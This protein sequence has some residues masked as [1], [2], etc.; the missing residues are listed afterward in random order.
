[1]KDKGVNVTRIFKEK[2]LKKTK[3]RRLFLTPENLII[4]SDTL[5][6]LMFEVRFLKGLNVQ[7][8][9]QFEFYYKDELYKISFNNPS[10]SAYKW[11]KILKLLQNINS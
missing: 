10:I 7:Y 1:M 9:N 4:K 2:I 11:Y 3:N 5:D 8:N 6:P